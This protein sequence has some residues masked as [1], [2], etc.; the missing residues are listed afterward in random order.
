M[1]IFTVL[2]LI[3]YTCKLNSGLLGLAIINLMY[4]LSHLPPML[5]YGCSASPNE[6]I[7]DESESKINTD[8]LSN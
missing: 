5:S 1:M 6:L 4:L 2:I 8:V 7:S 3:L